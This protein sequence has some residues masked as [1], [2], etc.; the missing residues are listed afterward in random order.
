MTPEGVVKEHVC[1]WLALRGGVEFW[2][3]NSVGVY[4]EKRKRF[5]KAKWHRSGQ[6]DLWGFLPDGRPFWI[7]LKSA[8]GRLT[9]DQEE[10][11]LIVRSRGHLAA[12]V[13]SIEDIEAA[14]SAWGA[15]G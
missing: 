3:T 14:F 9:A 12:V 15:L 8:K 1:H 13:R 7:E 5:R 4:D 2:T 10:F 11:L 6:S